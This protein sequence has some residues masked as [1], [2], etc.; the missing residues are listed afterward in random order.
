M[1]FNRCPWKKNEVRTC[2]PQR[3]AMAKRAVKKE[4]DSVA[5]FPDLARWTSPE[6]K[7]S[8][9][10]QMVAGWA[11][12]YRAVAA[13]QWKRARHELQNLP[14]ITAAGI[15]AHWQSDAFF[16]GDPVYLLT[17]IDQAKKGKSYWRLMR[18]KKQFELIRDGKLPKTVIQSIRAWD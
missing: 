17:A 13:V 6:E 1:K 9:H 12:H 11:V 4:L 3:L 15:K 7:I 18:I 14:R 10:D 8:P 16:P 2:S 5:L